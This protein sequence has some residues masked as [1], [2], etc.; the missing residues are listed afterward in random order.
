MR[1]FLLLSGV[2][3]GGVAL[4]FAVA[5]WRSSEAPATTAALPAAV[6][7]GAEVA[8]ADAES[9]FRAWVAALPPAPVPLTMRYELRAEAADSEGA[10]RRMELDV[11][12]VLGNLGS[13]RLDLVAR[14]GEGDAAPATLLDG[15]L[16]LDGGSFWAWG[17]L[18]TRPE[19]R[20]WTEGRVVRLPEEM[21]SMLFL[22]GARMVEA[23]GGGGWFGAAAGEELRIADRLH[24]SRLA[25]LLI[26][27]APVASLRLDDDLL[28]VEFRGGEMAF[29]GLITRGVAPDDARLLSEA[30]ANLAF[31]AATGE[32]LEGLIAWSGAQGSGSITMRSI[33]R[34]AAAPA[35]A[36]RYPEGATV[37]DLAPLA[38][39]GLGAMRRARGEMEADEDEAF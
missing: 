25:Q 9:A 12:M 32:L 10:E 3:G 27:R 20:K 16:V 23:L 5:V 24:P 31:D 34:E 8:E 13:L 22:E 37:F 33:A 36:F 35:S 28:R 21:L 26:G 15:A 7:A 29:L 38:Q 1:A 18:P 19:L 6:V 39:L 11:G 17:A 2:L 30:T 14:V 4:A